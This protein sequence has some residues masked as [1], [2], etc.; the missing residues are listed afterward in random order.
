[1]AI[2]P[3][4]TA[5]AVVAQ[6][7]QIPGTLLGDQHV[8]V[9]QHQQPPRIG[10]TGRERRCG[11]TGR[12]LQCLP[13]KGDRQRSV[14]DD[15]RCLWRRQLGRVDAEAP[16]DLVLGGEILRQLV[17]R[18]RSLTARHIVL[19]AHGHQRKCARGKPG[20]HD[21]AYVGIIRHGLP[22]TSDGSPADQFTRHLAAGIEVYL[23]RQDQGKKTLSI[24][25]CCLPQSPAKFPCCGYDK[26]PPSDLYEW[27]F[28]R[29]AGEHH[30]FPC[31]Q[32]KP[33]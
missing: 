2:D 18:S 11:E 1:M 6:Q 20:Q 19:D 5:R 13:V 14:G 29:N 25:R 32:G 17:L 33:G 4:R 9:G 24:F 15:R 23:M 12:D 10:K 8:A 16:A 27:N 31:S 28:W 30:C 7:G 22:P 3:D 26:I 21:V